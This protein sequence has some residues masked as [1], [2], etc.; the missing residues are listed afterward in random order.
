MSGHSKWHNI[1]LKKEKT[2]AAKGKIF[3]RISKEIMLAVREGGP[4]PDA[5][6]RLATVIEKAKGVNMPQSNIKR[7]IEK[8]SGTTAGE[9]IEEFVY[10]GYGPHGV[11]I[12]VH[13]ASDNKNR[14]VPEIR[15]IFS[16]YGGA[17]GEAGCVAWMF[18]KKG[19]ITVKTNSIAEEEL[20]ET[21]IEAGAEDLATIG[22][23]Y[24][25]TTEPS[26]FM[27]VKKALEA[28]KV[29]VESADLTMIAKTEVKLNKAQA[30]SIMKLMDALENHDD[31]QNVYA[32]FDIPEE[33]MAEL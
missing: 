11:A 26:S 3:T 6:Y 24:Q 13:S 5:N 10:E 27:A 29:P 8:A 30:E 16:K 4:D 19:I 20:F 12:L 9:N 7:A 1:R 31:V 15:N 17:M 18:D 33:V 22:E 23:F 25:I 32:N 28:K 14:T 2:D 21:V